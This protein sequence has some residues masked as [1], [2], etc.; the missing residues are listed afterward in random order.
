MHKTAL[1]VDE[2]RVQALSIRSHAL[3]LSIAESVDGRLWIGSD[4]GLSSLEP[5][6]VEA[7]VAPGFHGK[8]NCLFAADSGR[9]WV[10]TDDG[11]L[12]WEGKQMV[13][14]PI[15]DKTMQHLQVLTIL[16]DRDKHL[17]VGTS[18]GLLRFGP[19]GPEWVK[20]AT[21]AAGSPVTALLQDREGDIWFGSG[22]SLEQLKSTPIASLGVSCHMLS[23][24]FGP[25]YVDRRGRIWFAGLEH[26]LSW[27][28]GGRVKTVASDGLATD[29]VYSIDGEGD[30]LWVG[31]RRGG[32]TR[33]R[34]HNGT[35]ESK[36]WTTRDGLSQN[37][38]FAVRAVPGGAVWIG[39]LTG[40][41][42]LFS[43]SHFTHFNERD[44][45]P[46]DDVS[47]IELG[48]AGEVWIGTSN[49]VCRMQE[50]HC[51]SL[52]VG[53]Q[54]VARDVHTLLYDAAQGL[55]IGTSK[56]LLLADN[57]GEHPFRLKPSRRPTSWD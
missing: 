24:G 39:T 21:T 19:D 44:G 18:L 30:D 5:R 34:L 4:R 57:H 43:G 41:L 1:H 32:L 20:T 40:G 26:G 47:A 12:Y 9:I 48:R 56:G 22:S 36:T 38:V 54:P 10:G 23:S 51:V 6:S 42:N 49:G 16:E 7:E 29:E 2:D 52:V 35:M 14:A 3:L 15:P 8:V 55:W 27:M 31:R 37:S 13:R 28:E 17:W 45:L 11:L 46:A 33:L 50:R 53:R 25:L